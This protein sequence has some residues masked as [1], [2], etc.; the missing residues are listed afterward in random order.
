MST[1]STYRVA[2]INGPDVTAVLL[3]SAEDSNS[4]NLMIYSSVDQHGE[5]GLDWIRQCPVATEADYRALHQ[6]LSALYGPSGPAA[7]AGANDPVEL[8]IDQAALDTL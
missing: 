6:R 2:Y 1:L 4:G 7:S 8:V 5:A 3:D